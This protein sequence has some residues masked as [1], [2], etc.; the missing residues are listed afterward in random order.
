MVIIVC[1]SS[2]AS[3][4]IFTQLTMWEMPT[5]WQALLGLHSIKCFG[6]IYFF[7]SQAATGEKHPM[8]NGI[9]KFLQIGMLP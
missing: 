8:N 7:W 1:L 3:G 9:N 4:D 2:V 5:N 6:I